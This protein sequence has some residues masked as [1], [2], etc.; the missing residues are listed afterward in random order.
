MQLE[1]GELLPV[2]HG[3]I[4]L[5]ADSGCGRGVDVVDLPLDDSWIRD[6]GPVFARDS[7]GELVGV[8]FEGDK[9]FQA[10]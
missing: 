2:T 4:P 8:D 5:R 7:G 10:C 6:S 9:G 1:C 3:Q